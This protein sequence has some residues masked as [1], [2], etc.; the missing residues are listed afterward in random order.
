VLQNQTHVQ[1]LLQEFKC[2]NNRRK[3]INFKHVSPSYNV[4]E[5]HNTKDETPETHNRDKAFKTHKITIEKIITLIGVTM[6]VTNT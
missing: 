3:Q 1:N 6:S 4:L 5:S 2:K